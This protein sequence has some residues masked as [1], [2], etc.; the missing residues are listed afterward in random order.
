MKSNMMWQLNIEN[1]EKDI[2]VNVYLN[3]FSKSI[4]SK[5]LNRYIRKYKEKNCTNIQIFFWDT[6]IAGDYI[7][8]LQKNFDKSYL[9]QT[10]KGVKYIYAYFNFSNKIRSVYNP[11]VV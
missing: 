3:N 10:I 8:F 2:I 4:A 5:I 7:S 1:R 11:T 9:M 6:C